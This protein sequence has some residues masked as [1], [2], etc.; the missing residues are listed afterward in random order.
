MICKITSPVAVIVLPVPTV[1][2]PPELAVSVRL[3]IAPVDAAEIVAA[4]ESQTYTFPVVLRVTLEAESSNGEPDVPRVSEVLDGLVIDRLTLF[5]VSVLPA[6][7]T[8]IEV[9]VALS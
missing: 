6:E 4:R 2:L 5:A 7:P 8:V 9:A 3:N 1:M